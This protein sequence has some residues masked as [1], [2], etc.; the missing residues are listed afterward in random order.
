[1]K[2]IIDEV[3]CGISERDI[4]IYIINSAVN[5]RLKAKF[6]NKPPLKPV[7]SKEMWGRIQIDLM[8][9]TDVPVVVDGKCYQW[10]LS[11]MDVFSRYLVLKALHSKDTA[12]VAEQ[13]LR[14]LLI[15]EHQPSF[16]VSEAQ[17]SWGL[18]IS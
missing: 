14:F 5:Q 11:C 18:L 16:R 1:M 15:W 6:E 13:L 7:T 10:D 2:K 17:I 3:F 9:M 12:I 4:Q 8:S